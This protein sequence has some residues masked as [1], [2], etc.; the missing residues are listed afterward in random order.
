[1][2][3]GY[4]LWY[5]SC[6]QRTI[7]CQKLPVVQQRERRVSVVER[8]LRARDRIRHAQEAELLAL[9][10]EPRNASE[11][12]LRRWVWERFG[13][14][15]ADVRIHWWS[16]PPRGSVAML[17]L[18]GQDLASPLLVV[19]ERRRIGLPRVRCWVDEW[20]GA[21][22]VSDLPDLAVLGEAAA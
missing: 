16:T 5:A 6:E 9:V 19:I 17:H 1:M 18:D 10:M 11:R 22:P 4:R 14:S 20:P 2:Q 8:A 3:V 15:G 13:V 12:M 21:W 7:S